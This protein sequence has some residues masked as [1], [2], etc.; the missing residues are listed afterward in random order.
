MES[1]LK[2]GEVRD[3]GPVAGTGGVPGIPGIGAADLGEVVEI[4]GQPGKYLAI[5]GDSFSGNKMGDGEHYRSVAVPVTFD[6]EG[7]PHFGAPL[8]GPE[9]S[10]HEL[11]PSRATRKVSLTRCPRGRSRWE[12]KPT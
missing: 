6:A 8:T 10:G 5:F 3:L 2:P 1:P 7:H 11:F 12:T 9:G 4:P